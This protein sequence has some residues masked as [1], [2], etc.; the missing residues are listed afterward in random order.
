MSYCH[1]LLVRCGETSNQLPRSGLYRRCDM[2]SRIASGI[3]I[4]QQYVFEAVE[5]M[6]VYK[7]TA[8]EAIKC[9][10]SEESCCHG[11][12]LTQLLAA[13]VGFLVGPFFPGSC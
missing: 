3:L 7:D 4:V 10:L 5:A 13:M 8:Y 6:E 12:V 2:S 1:G 11:V 9:R